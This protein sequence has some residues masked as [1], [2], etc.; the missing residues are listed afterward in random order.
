MPEKK[1]LTP[2]ELRALADRI[3]SEECTGIAASWCPIHGDCT[4]PKDDDERRIDDDWRGSRCALHG[5]ASSHAEAF[6]QDVR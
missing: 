3:E 1:E 5:A 2:A 4:C 6:A